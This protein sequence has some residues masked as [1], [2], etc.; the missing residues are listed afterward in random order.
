VATNHLYQGI[1]QAIAVA[2]ANSGANLA[3]LELESQDISETKAS[4][5]KHNVKVETYA[6]DVTKEQEVHDVFAKIAQDL[7]QVE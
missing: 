4:C 2:L 6:C 5:E 3:L 1:G 7:G